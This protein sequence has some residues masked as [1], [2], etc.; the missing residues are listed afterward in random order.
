M[1]GFAEKDGIGWSGAQASTSWTQARTKK[2]AFES[3]TEAVQLWFESCIERS[4]LDIALRETGFEKV[5]ARRRGFTGDR[6]RLCPKWNKDAIFRKIA[7]EVK[8]KDKG[9]SSPDQKLNCETRSRYL[10]FQN[11]ASPR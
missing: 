9:K 7:I 8:A 11:S 1:R 3:L 4:V 10:W 6:L 2:K 5:L